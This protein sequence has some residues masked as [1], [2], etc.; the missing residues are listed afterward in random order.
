MPKQRPSQGSAAHRVRAA[1]PWG[2]V[3]LLF[4]PLLVSGA[5]YYPYVTPKTFFIET[6]G[7][8]L[9]AAFSFSALSGEDFY[10]AR[11]RHPAAWIPAALLAVEYLTSFFGAD[12]YRSFWGYLSRGDGLLV[13]TFLVGAFY[14]TL[15]V[16]DERFWRYVARSLAA[17]I[18]ILSAI[19]AL[20]WLAYVLGIAFPFVPGGADR[21]G[22]LFGNAAYLASYLSFA[23]LALLALPEARTKAYRAVAAAGIV[24]AVLT[25]TRG[26]LLALAAALF[27]FLAY[28]AF[29][30]QGTSR[31]ASRI[32]LFALFAAAALFFAFR[33]PLS[34]SPF[35]P[36][37]RLASISLSDTTTASRLFVWE[38]VFS[39]AL[40]HP[41]FGVGAS[42]I[43]TLFDRAYDPLKI[44]EEW[45]DRTH[46]AF[47]DYFA[48]YGIAG[49]G[50]FLA[51]IGA[52]AAFAWKAWRPGGGY[53]FALV[54]ILAYVIQ[55]IFFFDSP[56]LFLLFLLLFA[57]VLSSSAPLRA[58]RAFPSALSVSAGAVLGV[59]FVV[60]CYPVVV[61]P[62]IAMRDL[63]VG[64]AYWTSEPARSLAALKSGSALSTY[65]DSEYGYELAALY[66]AENGASLPAR[67][68]V[69]EP[70]L[71]R[72]FARYPYDTHAALA[73]ATVVDAT[74]ASSAED[75]ALEASALT[76]AMT[77]S[78]LRA[79][80]Y[81]LAANL[82][83]SDAASLPPGKERDAA[84]SGVI[85]VLKKYASLEPALALP[86]FTLAELYLE[87][88]DASSAASEA[89]LGKS[90][91]VSDLATAH[92]AAAYYLAARSWPDAQSFLGDILRLDPAD[93]ASALDLAKVRYISG[94]AAGARS[95][96]EGLRRTDPSALAGQDAFL[97]LLGY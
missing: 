9:A 84:L 1:L 15:L 42:H 50:L 51:L 12:F 44:G 76:R 36:V 85:A 93:G 94:D 53:G 58:L 97:H 21:V 67:Y 54:A 89:A 71:A 34:H 66:T 49:L 31:R 28:A 46:D 27:A 72:D 79:E 23:S 78:P 91:Y 59:A 90:A 43:E 29:A 68:A 82:A 8:L 35:E 41:F 65:A 10:L 20:E 32:A 47:L 6:I 24:M 5:L 48:E 88:G 30:G 74:P 14:L 39:E 56:E 2:L 63:A 4:A 80:S 87:E 64:Y 73:L 17:V 62:L 7:L 61:R 45:F 77:L 52:A 25:A 3:A 33:T 18:G 22:S 26:S 40:A 75:R 70:I 16:A 37:R 57:F 38:H 96:V 69:V 19:G 11:L 81:Y 95:I 86:H 55:D 60:A 92:R 13:T 83:L